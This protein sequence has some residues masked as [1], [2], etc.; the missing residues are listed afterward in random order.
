MQA[1]IIFQRLT[2]LQRGL[3]R[4]IWF[5]K[6]DKRHPVSGRE[7]DEVFIRLAA[8]ELVRGSDELIELL[9]QL[10]LLIYKQLR[11]TDDIDEQD[12]RDLRLKIR[13]RFSGHM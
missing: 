11:I 10:C 4:R 6:K 5:G 13:F 12:M 9:K 7:T 1:G 8:S 3:R 2:N